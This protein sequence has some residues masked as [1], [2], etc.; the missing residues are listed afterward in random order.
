MRR[1]LEA[2]LALEAARGRVDLEL[3]GGHETRS[4]AADNNRFRLDLRLGF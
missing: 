2:G 4:G 1:K 3:T